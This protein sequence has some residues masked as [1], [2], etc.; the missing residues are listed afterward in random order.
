MSFDINS[1]CA[2]VNSLGVACQGVNWFPKGHPVLNLTVDIH[3][4]LKVP[5]YDQRGVLTQRHTPL[6]KI[7]YYCFSSIIGIETLLIYVFFLALHAKSDYDH[8]TYLSKEDQGL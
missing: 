6:F 5:V 3:F 4:G 8:S 2:F 1:T 7:P